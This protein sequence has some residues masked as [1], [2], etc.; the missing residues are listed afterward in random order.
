MVQ[1][2][3]SQLTLTEVVN[4]TLYQS[5][6][7]LFLFFYCCIFK[8]FK[9]DEYHCRAEFLNEFLPQIGQHSGSITAFAFIPSLGS[10]RELLPKIPTVSTGRRPLS[11][12][13]LSITTIALLQA[14]N[15]NTIYLG[16]LTL[17]S[18]LP[19]YYSLLWHIQRFQ[20]PYYGST[21]RS[22]PTCQIG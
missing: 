17:Q 19:I 8:L 12:I 1:S 14:P 21:H 2:F 16:I 20:K 22:T 4:S 15:S 10:F 11:W 5:L 3:L 9:K 13:Y 6:F 7:D 18:Q